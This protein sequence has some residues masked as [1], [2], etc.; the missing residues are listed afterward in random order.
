M[1]SEGV[2]CRNFPFDIRG[3]LSPK[4]GIRSKKSERHGK[5]WSREQIERGS[6]QISGYY[7]GETIVFPLQGSR[8]GLANSDPG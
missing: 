7:H 4:M 1:D 8:T 6:G 5:V 3:S 2:S